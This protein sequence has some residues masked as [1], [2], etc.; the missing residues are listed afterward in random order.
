MVLI[1]TIEK[2]YSIFNFERY[3]EHFNVIQKC[4]NFDLAFHI[5][6]ISAQPLRCKTKLKNLVFS[7]RSKKP[8]PHRLSIFT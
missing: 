8:A 2:E 7:A 3:Y 5:K 6:L 4:L 1:C